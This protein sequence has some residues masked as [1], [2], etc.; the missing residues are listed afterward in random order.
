MSLAYGDD[1]TSELCTVHSIR[2][3]VS[4][5]PDVF[6]SV[7]I[8]LSCQHPANERGKSTKNLA[9]R[10]RAGSHVYNYVGIFLA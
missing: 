6:N 4:G 7:H 10:D 5:G 3:C 8:S 2:V 9:R 1:T